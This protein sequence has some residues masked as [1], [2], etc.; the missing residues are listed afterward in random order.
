MIREGELELWMGVE[1]DCEAECLMISEAVLMV[2][3]VRRM[4]DGIL[5]SGVFRNVPALL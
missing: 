3:V 4:K 5:E 2:V 1:L